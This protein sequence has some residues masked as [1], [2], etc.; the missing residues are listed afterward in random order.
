MPE[1]RAD[2]PQAPAA[3]AAF[4]RGVERRGALFAQLQC[5]D[6]ERGDVALA[7][8]MRDFSAEAA[9]LPMADWP[10]RFWQRLADAMVFRQPVAGARWPGPVAHLGQ[11]A[12]PDRKA[13]LTRLAAG[14]P[15]DEAAEVL[16]SDLLHYRA[17]L[18]AACP[19]DAAGQ[20]DAQGWRA[21]AEAIQ[22]QM[23]DLPPDRLARLAR[24]R[25]RALSPEAAR[26]L[27]PTSPPPANAAASGDAEG[28]NARGRWQRWGIALIVALCVA[29][30]VV[31][32]LRPQWLLQEGQLPGRAPGGPGLGLAEEPEI[33]MEAL[34]PADVPAARVEPADALML[35]PDLALL[36]D[37]ADEA[38][39]Q[40]ADF[41]A[42][43]LAGS[44]PATPAEVPQEGDAATQE[45]GRDTTF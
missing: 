9:D 23:R 1:S 10:R 13:L 31:S 45:E 19:V 12:P 33:R 16:G 17:A 40:Q 6:A 35:H 21:L 37:P 38:I 3:L 15:E 27:P 36:R 20:P 26:A 11:L 34:P 14:L 32:Y 28:N 44:L 5:G 7:T 22:Q 24:L 2:A 18:A 39:A 30:I 42:W 41:Y 29:A 8:T 25:E 4:L 43:Y